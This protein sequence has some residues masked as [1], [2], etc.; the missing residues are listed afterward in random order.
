MNINDL[1]IAL[2]QYIAQ[3]VVSQVRDSWMRFLYLVG[4]KA[5]LPGCIAEFMPMAR[6][7]CFV[8]DSGNIDLDKLQTIL[9]DTFKE[10]PNIQYGDFGFTAADVPHF[11]NFL[12]NGNK[13]VKQ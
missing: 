2:Y 5:V 1:E 3:H 11:I 12:K 9:Q 6:K 7:C 8:D 10:I 4:I 13:E